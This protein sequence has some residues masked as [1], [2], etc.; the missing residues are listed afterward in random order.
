MKN[1][2]I[3]NVLKKLFNVSRKPYKP[4]R[5]SV[6]GKPAKRQREAL[7]KPVVS[8]LGIMSFPERV[9]KYIWKTIIKATF[10]V[11]VFAMCEKI[12]SP[13]EYQCSE[14]RGNVIVKPL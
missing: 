3:H 8:L 4:L 11:C 10:R 7:I 5:N 13:W 2:Y 6:F 12:D 14:G 1:H 9:L